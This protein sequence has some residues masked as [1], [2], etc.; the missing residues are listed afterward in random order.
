[1]NSHL[2]IDSDHNYIDNFEL[3]EKKY[4]EFYNEEVNT[5]KIHYLYINEFNEI[6]NI[7]SEYEVLNNSC[8]TKERILYLIKK[9]QYN[10][11]NK[12]KLISCL[13]YNIDFDF[14]ELNNFLNNKLDTNFLVPLKIIDDILF[15]KTISI[16]HNLNCVFFLFSNNIIQTHNN[17][18][19]IT[20]CTNNS[21]TRRNRK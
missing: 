9:N 11:S 7:K 8:I 15:N 18:K 6:Y 4:N 16:L 13:K 2:T 17:T 10:L 12:H 1:M 14:T 3:L 5:I 21:K 20:I 19:K